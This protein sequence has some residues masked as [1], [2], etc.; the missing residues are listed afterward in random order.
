MIISAL[1][2]D[3]VDNALILYDKD[4]FFTNIL[5]TLKGG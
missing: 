3:M 5:E 2:L 1:Y 4:G